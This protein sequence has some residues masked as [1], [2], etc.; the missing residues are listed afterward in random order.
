MLCHTGTLKNQCTIQT[1]SMRTEWSCSTSNIYSWVFTIPCSQGAALFVG[2]SIP[3][4]LFSPFI[5]IFGWMV[6]VHSIKFIFHIV[7]GAPIPILSISGNNILWFIDYQGFNFFFPL[8]ITMVE[9]PSFSVSVSRFC[10]IFLIELFQVKKYPPYKLDKQV[11]SVRI[12]SSLW[13]VLVHDFSA[14]ML[15]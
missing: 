5:M 7:L 6:H 13:F 9:V 10:Y 3:Q 2:F 1:A 14:T 15:F 8:N 12:L 11:V 4:I